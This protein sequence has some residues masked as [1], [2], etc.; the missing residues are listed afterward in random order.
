M[1]SS[2]SGE[3]VWHAL[4]EPWIEFKVR[5]GLH[6][7]LTPIGDGKLHKQIVGHTGTIRSATEQYTIHSAAA[8][9]SSDL[10][11]VPK[12]YGLVNHRSYVMEHIYGGFNY[13][14][15]CYHLHPLLVEEL[16]KFSVF[17]KQRGYYPYGYSVLQTEINRFVLVDFSG[18]GTIDRGF[19]SFKHNKAPL[20]IDDVDIHYGL[21]SDIYVITEDDLYL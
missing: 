20:S 5:Q 7:L 13:P 2:L 8:E 14:K 15:N 3:I 1:S 18:F 17:M 4:K 10:L 16:E 21:I 19:V 6:H 9:F 11:R 12:L